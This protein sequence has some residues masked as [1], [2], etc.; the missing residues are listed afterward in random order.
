MENIDNSTPI[1]KQGSEEVRLNVVENLKCSIN[2]ELAALANDSYTVCIFRVSEKYRK[3][4]EAAYTPR[5]VSVGPLHHGKSHLQAM[6]AYKIRYLHSFLYRFGIDIDKLITYA[7]DMEDKVRGCYEDTSKFE[8]EKFCRMI[9]LDGIFVVQL[10]VKNLIIQMRESG[11]MLF[12][13]Q[14]MAS[15]LMHDM[16]LLEN[17]LPLNVILGLF[18]FVNGS[19]VHQKSFYDLSLD[20]FKGVG[21]TE[22]LKLTP[23]CGH[24]RH[25][26]EFLVILHRPSSNRQQAPSGTGRCQYTR[27]ASQ[28]HAAGVRFFQGMGELFEVSFDKKVGLLQLP[29]LTVNDK[30]ETFFRNLIAYEQC[31]HYGKYI[32]SYI[33]FMDTLINTAED[34]ELLVDCKVLENLLGENQQVADLFNNVYKE[35]IEEQ[36]DFYFAEICNNLDDYSKDYIHEWKSAWFKWKLILKNEYFSNP[37][38]LVAFMA[39]SAVI[40]LTIVQTVCSVLGL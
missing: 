22:K 1:L 5:V 3:S 19:L 20:Y 25:L 39:A 28:L 14:W 7:T 34:V 30:T 18:N 16:L 38:S 33:I 13:N 11:D 10:F 17:Q 37:W 40:L 29:Q 12:E 32:T 21:N 26:V 4:K 9:L 27:S 8:S 23:G 2:K 24:S 15:D 31:G 35:V 6:E 36:K